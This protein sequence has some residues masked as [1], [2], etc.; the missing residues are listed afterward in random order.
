MNKKRILSSVLCGLISVLSMTSCDNSQTNGKKQL[1]IGLE[2]NYTPFNWTELSGNEYTLP[3]SNV[4]D[5]YADGYDIQIAKY[6]GEK[7]DYEIVIKK[8]EWDALLTSMVTDDIN[9]IIAGMS[10]SEERDLTIDFTNNYYTSEMTIV[11]RK[12]SPLVNITNVNELA[13]YKVVSQR[14][15]LTYDI[16]DQIPNVIKQPALDSFAVA[17]LS[18]ASGTSDAMTAEYPVAKAIVNGNSALTLVTFSK[19][20]GF[21]NLDENELGVAIGIQEGNKELKEL[22]NNALNELSNEQRKEM[23]DGAI[24]RAPGSDN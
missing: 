4:S 21:Q 20:N 1:V 14:G 16:I 13:N 10:Y 8:L 6:L 2:C 3:I 22:I 17:S 15:T 18:V 23:M 19:E 11:V 24:K 5:S 12:D 9:C 7:L